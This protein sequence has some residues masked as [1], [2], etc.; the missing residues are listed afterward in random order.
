MSAIVCGV[1][2]FRWKEDALLR[3]SDRTAVLAFTGM[4]IDL[5]TE[6]PVRQS[7]W[8]EAECV[9]RRTIDVTRGGTV[10]DYDAVL[11]AHGRTLYVQM[12]PCDL[13]N[14]PLAYHR[15]RVRLPRRV[16]ASW[17]QLIS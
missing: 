10:A 7:M 6:R 8:D 14:D 11:R 1:K 3:I 16:T 12:L 17:A 4:R 15:F 2:G 13:T 5:H 9:V